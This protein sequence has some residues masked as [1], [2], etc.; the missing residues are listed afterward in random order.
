MGE[1]VQMDKN[2]YLSLVSGL[3]SYRIW[4]SGVESMEEALLHSLTTPIVGSY[5]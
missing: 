3:N 5:K 4:F 1:S 2:A